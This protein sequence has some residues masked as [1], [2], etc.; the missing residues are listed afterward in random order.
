MFVEEHKK[1]GVEFYSD[2]EVT[3]ITSWPDT[4]KVHSVKLSSGKVLLADMVIFGTGVAPATSFLE[5]SGIEVSPNG[6][7]VCDE[8]LRTNIPDI[9]A[10]GDIIEYPYQG[11]QV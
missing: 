1:N 6:N 8:F 4:K 5:Y 3:Q 10:A 7:V 11:E 9:Y 2:S